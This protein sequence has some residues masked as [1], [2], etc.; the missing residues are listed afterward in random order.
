M[1]PDNTLVDKIRAILRK[2]EESTNEHEAERDTAMRMAQRL[3]LKHGLT[4][5]DVG[6]LET[7]ERAFEQEHNI[8][9]T[10]RASNW[11]GTLLNRIA[12]VYFCQVYFIPVSS[13]HRTWTVL[14]RQDHVE[15]TK[16]MF[17]FVWPQIQREL[18]VAQSKMGLYQRIARRYCLALVED[19]AEITDEELAEIG[20]ERLANME[21]LGADYQ[22]ADVRD[23]LDLNSLQYAKNALRFIRRG[24][25]APADTDNL[26]R[27]RN[28]FL[29][30]AASR[31]GSRL[32]ELRTEEVEDLGEPGMALVR[33]EKA[34][35][36]NYLESLDLGLRSSTS[37]RGYDGAGSSAG[38]EAGDRA[39]LSGHRKVANGGRK[40]LN[41]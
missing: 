8:T 10:D 11:K 20:M 36:E 33:N 4:M 17:E 40:E 16:M 32:R 19:P 1:T 22:A 38:R 39:D 27:W 18:D 30:S 26:K 29:D 37:S 12:R 5:S 15:A 31:I 23:L 6:S 35:L 7:D 34:A 13:K 25:I 2:A 28:S 24:E 14:G 21:A 9:D 41:S 3:L